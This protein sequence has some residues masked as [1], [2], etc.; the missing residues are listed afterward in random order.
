[1]PLCEGPAAGLGPLTS[2]VEASSPVT[3]RG[4]GGAVEIAIDTV[5]P[6][7]VRLRSGEERDWMGT[8]LE[9]R[10]LRGAFKARELP[11]PA[12]PDARCSLGTAAGR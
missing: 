12:R 11:T 7:V 1:M 3:L 6:V 2:P 10:R 5:L 8:F 4:D 9:E